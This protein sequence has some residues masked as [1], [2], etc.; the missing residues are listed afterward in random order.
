MKHIGADI[1]ISLSFQII[2]GRRVFQYQINM[3]LKERY[4]DT[5][6]SNLD[7][8]P[9]RP[10]DC[11]YTNGRIAGHNVHNIEY[12]KWNFT[13][14]TESKRDN[15]IEKEQH[16]K[17]PIRKPNTVRYPWTMV[18]HVEYASLAGRTVVA[19][20]LWARDYL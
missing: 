18:V 4:D 15:D 11:M 3:E 19:S 12:K 5:I 20:R 8:G 14:D 17:L 10:E 1:G 6:E 16:K 7:K 2:E 13:G 9:Y